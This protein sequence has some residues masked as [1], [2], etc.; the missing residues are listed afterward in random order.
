M[1]DIVCSIITV[2]YN[3]EKT[4]KKTIES[5]LNQ[6]YKGYEY[7]II[8]GNSTD[9]TVNIIKEYESQFDGRMKWI[10]EPDH[11][12]YDAMNK[13]IRMASGQLIGIINSD[14]FY[15]TDAVEQMVETMSEQPYQILYGAIR[16]LHNGVEKSIS[17]NSH[18]F[19][20]ESMIGHPACFITKQLYDDLGVYNTQFIS[21][22]DY[23]FMLRMIQDKRVVFTPVYRVI[24]N[25]STGGM[26][27]SSK[28]YYD[29]LK[30]RKKHNL[31]SSSE[32]KKTVIKCKIYDF[33]H[34]QK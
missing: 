20:Q 14:D 3:S 5:V 22:A 9:G 23:D 19:L 34:G 4:I 24:A 7:I 17:I 33:L 26:C 1:K 29:L 13:G 12:I 18:L 8:D 2:S 32:Y 10:S 25:F 6:S 27:A 31:I 16:T 21:A 11:G 28:A 15:E 30:V